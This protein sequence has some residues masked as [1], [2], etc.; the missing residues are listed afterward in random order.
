MDW[1]NG[2]M[3][4]DLR[5]SGN[6]RSAQPIADLSSIRSDVLRRFVA[7]W[8][9]IRGV[10]RMPTRRDFDPLDAR[11]A[12]GY[13]SL[14]EVHRDPMRFYFRLDGTNQVE[15]FGIDCTRR[16]LDEAMPSEHAAMA[17]ISYTDVVQH[18]EPRYHRRQI[19]FHERLI[20]WEVV[21]LPFSN[22]GERVDRLMTGIVPDQ[23]L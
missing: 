17:S 10:R 4:T 7:Y 6:E 20:D 16:Y 12:L 11:F 13:I 9:E 1:D 8:R 3:S 23:S 14:I 21:I 22:D 2:P 19:V 5:R 15:L 18:G